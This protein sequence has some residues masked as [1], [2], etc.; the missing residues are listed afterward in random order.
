M[1]FTSK[2]SA[3]QIVIPM[4]ET[5]TN[6]MKAYGIAYWVLKQNV[7]I[8]WLL[9]Y[10]GGS[11]ATPLATDIE[12]ECKIR[13]VSYE[14]VP[15]GQ[16]NLILADIANPE[17]NMDV[18]KLEESSEVCVY[19]PKTKQ[20]W[21]DATLV[22]TYAEIPYEIVYDDEILD[23]KLLLDDWLHSHD[24][25]FTGQYGKFFA[26]Y[27]GAQ[28]YQNEVADQ[29]ARAKRRG[30]EQGKRNEVG[31]SQANPRFYYRW[32]LYVCFV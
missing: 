20:P 28:W 26:S 21:D 9:N 16:Y 10:R 8:D 18:M 14:V 6:H 27:G 4:D 30:F 2:V 25:D 31:R 23:G 24:E 29:E 11:F 7:T 5:Q 32:W 17:Q 3:S 15:A 19:S 22:L 13:G 12:K 1:L